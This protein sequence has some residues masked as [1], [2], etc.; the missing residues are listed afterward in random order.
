MTPLTI[1]LQVIIDSICQMF[2]V[3]F[4]LSLLLCLV[5]KI[6]VLFT[7]FVFGKEIKF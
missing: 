2:I 7:R 4:P 3:A 6:T 5:S 1:D